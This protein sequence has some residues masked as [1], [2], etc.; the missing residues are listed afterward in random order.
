[1]S[2]TPGPWKVGHR[3]NVVVDDSGTIIA[4]CEFSHSAKNRRKPTGDE[5]IANAALIAAA[6]E[7]LA[8][9]GSAHDCLGFGTEGD[10]NLREKI[11][12]AIAKAE[13]GL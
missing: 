1:M 5:S 7:M 8:L 13:E 9:L 2:H 12:N 11:R 3:K 4:N 6:P 10:R